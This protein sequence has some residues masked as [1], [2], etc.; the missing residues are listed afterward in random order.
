MERTRETKVQKPDTTQPSNKINQ[1]HTQNLT[2]KLI[3]RYKN[4]VHGLW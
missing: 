1:D 2:K 4:M 3:N